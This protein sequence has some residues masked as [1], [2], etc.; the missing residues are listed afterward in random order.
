MQVLERKQAEGP[1]YVPDAMAALLALSQGEPP[2][3]PSHWTSRGQ[4]ALIGVAP[5][6]RGRER[7]ECRL[8]PSSCACAAS[9]TVHSPSCPYCSKG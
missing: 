3:P 2:N 7:H 1:D 4:Q 6:Q 5:R 8:F 9:C